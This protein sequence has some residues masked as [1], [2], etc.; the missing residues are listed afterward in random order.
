[1]HV[2]SALGV[3]I[4]HAV[5]ATLCRIH[6][7][8]LVET[9]FLSLNQ[10]KALAL[11]LVVRRR[12]RKAAARKVWVHETLRSREQL[13]EFRLVKELRFHCDRFQGYF[14]SADESWFYDFPDTNN[15]AIAHFYIGLSGYLSLP[16]VW[17]QIRQYGKVL[18]SLPL[19]H[20]F[21]S[22]LLCTSPIGSSTFSY[23]PPLNR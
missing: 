4:R 3:Y 14:W 22:S 18:P 6:S 15:I 1:M 8:D 20:F 13:G 16:D 11:A 19:H 2:T 21:V 7:S 9:M 12:Q 10:K 17:L 23:T 5:H